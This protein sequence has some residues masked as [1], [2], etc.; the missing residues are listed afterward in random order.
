MVRVWSKQVNRKEGRGGLCKKRTARGVFETRR[1][2]NTESQR[3]KQPI[4]RIHS[5]ERG[6]V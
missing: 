3:G 5:G 1:E 6:C 4:E 2:V